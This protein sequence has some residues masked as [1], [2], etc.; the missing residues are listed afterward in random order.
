[1]SIGSIRVGFSLISLLFL[2]LYSAPVVAQTGTDMDMGMATGDTGGTGDTDMTS[3]DGV[4]E[5]SGGAVSTA[6]MIVLGGLFL[7][8]DWRNRR[9][10]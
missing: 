3:P 5:L 8:I 4:P 7:F 2:L 1:M 6:I 9:N 10:R